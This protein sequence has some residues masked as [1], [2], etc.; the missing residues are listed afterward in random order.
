MRNPLFKNGDYYMKKKIYIYLCTV[1]IVASNLLMISVINSGEEVLS[2]IFVIAIALL[3]FPGFLW[4]INNELVSFIRVES[5]ALLMLAIISVMRLINRIDTLPP[6]INS[7]AIII[8]IGIGIL[9][10][11]V[12]IVRSV[13]KKN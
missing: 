4:A 3:L 1:V 13:N 2:N 12:A 8:A 6:V 7:V 10:V 9:L 11:A 5:C